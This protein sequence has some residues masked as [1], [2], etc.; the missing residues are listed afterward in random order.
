VS[1]PL[2]VLLL[3]AVLAAAPP[4]RANAPGMPTA[5]A[6]CPA[7]SGDAVIMGYG[8]AALR[9]SKRDPE[10]KGDWASLCLPLKRAGNLLLVEARVDSLVGNF[11]LDFGAPY[12]VLNRTYFRDYETQRSGLQASG[13]DGGERA[14]ERITVDRL[15][16]ETLHWL[17]VEADLANLGAI[18]DRRGVQI[19]GLMGL[20][21]FLDL[22]VTIDPLQS[23]LTLQR[24]DE[25][26]APVDP[27]AWDGRSPGMRTEIRVREKRILLEG[28]VA[29]KRL[30]FLLD[31]GAEANVL[32]NNNASK[33]LRAV[34]IERR[35][36]LHGSA[37]GRAEALA[38]ELG[39]LELGG[40][41]FPG[42]KTLIADLDGLGTATGAR[43]PG[44]SRPS[45]T[46]ITAS[47]RSG[48]CPTTGSRWPAI[49]TRAGW[50]SPGPSTAGGR[51]NRR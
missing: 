10:P 9:R 37:G 22:A 41:I 14:V 36:P 45:P 29:G 5:P 26:G 42:G 23:V 34:R 32:D 43:T 39:D 12:L 20:D 48:T 19:L 30:G 21:L 47:T 8:A 28:R 31:T 11:I 49:R 38:G 46:G 27:D 51:R 13:V 18:E 2:H 35:V 7:D 24:L 1:V 17:D 3:G 33:V 40:R 44:T 15:E 25:A 6:A 16:M 4:V 50:W